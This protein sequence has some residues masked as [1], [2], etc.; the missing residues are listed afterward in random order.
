[1]TIKEKITI[2]KSFSPFAILP[3]KELVV[4]AKHAKEKIF[5]IKSFLVEQGK[6][7]EVV[8]LVYG[9]LIQIYISTG[10]GKTIPIRVKEAPYIVG[11]M[12]LFDNLATTNIQVL[13]QTFTLVLSQK[14]F[15]KL[16]STYP[17]VSLELLKTFNEKLRAANLHTEYFF[18]QRLKERLLTILQTLAKHFPNNE[19]YL[20][21][22]ELAYIVGASRSKVTIILDELQK[23]NII[24]L[25]HKKIHLL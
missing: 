1:M 13:Q 9:G 21:Q 8:Y 22:E 2:T 15:L 17:R 23:D 19:I 4:L 14:I 16:L 10:E 11:E 20:S 7:A 3:K 12:N 24:S 25:S 6:P 5:P 18:S